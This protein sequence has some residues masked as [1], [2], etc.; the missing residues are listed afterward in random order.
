MEKR[1]RNRTA[2]FRGRNG[3][4]SAIAGALVAAP[5]KSLFRI[6]VRFQV[7]M[8][9]SAADAAVRCGNNDIP[10]RRRTTAPRFQMAPIATR[11]MVES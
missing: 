9:S 7:K 5:A 10:T 4:R 6:G 3:D 8:L 11:V 1:W 2:A